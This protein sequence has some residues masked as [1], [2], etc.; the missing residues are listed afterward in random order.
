MNSRCLSLVLVLVAGPGCESLSMNDGKFESVM[1]AG[2]AGKFHREMGRWP[3]SQGEL[4]THGCPDLDESRA[5][6]AVIAQAH[7]P[8]APGCQF[9]VNLPYKVQLEQRDGNLRMVLRD[10]ANK[11]VCRLEVVVPSFDSARSLLPQVRIRTTMF[12][13]PGEG[14]PW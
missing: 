8:A 7:P 10:A 14:K 12:T 3:R 13:C 6:V 5:E 2:Q 4:I 9:F 1:A 11:L